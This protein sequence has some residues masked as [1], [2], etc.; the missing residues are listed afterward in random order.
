MAMSPA[1]FAVVARAVFAP[2]DPGY[3]NKTFARVDKE[4]CES[5][6]GASY[7]I[8]AELWNLINPVATM[9]KDAKAKHLL[10]ALL[11]MMNYATEVLNTRV[12]G[13]VDVQTF[14]KWSWLFIDAIAGLKNQVVSSTFMVLVSIWLL[15]LTLHHTGCATLRLSGTIAFAAGTGNHSV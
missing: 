13:G 7:E 14:R 2:R 6:I 15:E 10:W 9:S 8:C 4:I 1:E 5:L 12:V 11:L 3:R